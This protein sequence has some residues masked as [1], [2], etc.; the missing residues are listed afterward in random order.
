MSRAFRSPTSACE[1]RTSVTSLFAIE[2]LDAVTLAR[3]SSGV[4]VVAEGLHGKPIVNC[5]GLFVWLEE[6]SEPLQKV[7]IDPGTLP[8]E[9]VE[10]DEGATEPSAGARAADHDRAAAARWTTRSQAGMTGV[11]GTL[12]EDRITAGPTRC[13]GARCALRWLDDDGVTGATR[14]RH[15]H[16]NADGDFVSIPALRAQPMFHVSIASR[17]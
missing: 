16:T 7:S 15:S 10:R 6:P 2:L 11:R 8:Y 17:R 14:R 3:V 9:R 4:K 5:G 13:A 1:R 12:I